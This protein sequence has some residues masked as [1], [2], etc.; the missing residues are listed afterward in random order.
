MTSA[1]PSSETSQ[2]CSRY[3]YSTRT[4]KE[5]YFTVPVGIRE[6]FQELRGTML[7]SQSSRRGRRSWEIICSRAF[8]VVFLL[9]DLC[10]FDLFVALLVPC[11]T[12]DSTI[13]FA[14]DSQQVRVSGSLLDVF[15][16]WQWQPGARRCA[17]WRD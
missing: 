17:C 12:S 10:A 5:G 15:P 14:T 1:D 2:T 8:K 4:H 11:S 3:L 16:V 7:T 9:V 13:L 6:V